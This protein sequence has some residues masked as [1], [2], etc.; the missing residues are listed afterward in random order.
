MRTLK[1]LLIELEAGLRDGTIVLDNA[2]GAAEPRQAYPP[3]PDDSRVTVGP[4]I[5]GG[6]PG[7]RAVN[8]TVWLCLALAAVALAVLALAAAW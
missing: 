2:E 6:G 1:S 5:D 8:R 3:P 4:Q 7:E